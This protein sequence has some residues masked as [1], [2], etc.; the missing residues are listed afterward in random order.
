MAN[1]SKTSRTFMV[2]VATAA[3]AATAVAPIASAASF[4]DT[5]GNTHEQAINA[6]V[7][8]GIIGGYPDGTF[9]PNR[10]LTRSDVVKMMGKWLVSLGYEVP[11]DYK[12][13]P[14]FTDLTTKTNDELL[15]YSALVKDNRVFGGYEDGS[16]GPSKPITRENMAIVLV[17]AYDAIHK[18]D[19][20]AYVGD[21]TFNRDV[22]DMAKAKA[23]ARPS[24]DVLD[25]FNITGV[26]EFMPKN[27]TTR[28]QFASFLFKASNLEAPDQN[29]DKEA[30]KLNYTGKRILN[31]HKALRSPS[32]P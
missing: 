6:L 30:P 31:W 9:Q 8:A 1:Q 14:R 10:T 22:T 15:K 20:V 32:R 23:E 26:S 24:I 12:T 16:L 27:S 4:S 2:G 3:L 13:N 28:G 17:R 5:V 29:L 25:Y 21:Q 18:T 7:E 19:L 11:S